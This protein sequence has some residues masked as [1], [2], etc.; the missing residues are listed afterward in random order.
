M[1]TKIRSGLYTLDYRKL[2]SSYSKLLQRL[3]VSDGSGFSLVMPILG[4]RFYLVLFDD[5]YLI[6]LSKDIYLGLTR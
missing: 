6:A 4:N 5:I 3:N 1:N 2:D